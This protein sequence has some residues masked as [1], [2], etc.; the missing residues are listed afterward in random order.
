MSGDGEPGGWSPP[1]DGVL[2]QV[3]DGT[4]AGVGI[5]DPQ[6]RYVYVNPALARMNGLPAEA[7]LG[8]RITEVLPDL[9]DAGEE[10]LRQVLS[11]G[12]SRE[13]P[14]SG[15]THAESGTGRRYWQGAY[16]RLDA[17][18]GTVLGLV[19]IML[20]VSASRQHQQ[21]LERAR[22]RLAILDRAATFIGTTLEMDETC[23]ELAGFLVPLLADIATVEVFPTE[24]STPYNRGLLRLRRAAMAALP[25]LR[26]QVKIFGE[27][28]EYVEYPSGTTIP[29]CL[30][31]GSPVVQ[32]L[33]EDDALGHGGSARE[34]MAAFRSV[35]I[36][37]ALVVPLAAR[38][39]PIGTVTLVRC[40]E[41]PGF[42]ERDT[43]TVQDIV[44]RAAIYLDNAR[45]Y[46]HEHG[47][48]LELQRA[49]MSEPGSPHPSVEAAFRYQPAGS[50]AL[51]GGDWYDAVRLSYGR[52]LLAMG[53]VMGHGVEASVDMSQYRSML[54]FVA[55]ADLP[56][57]RI[58]RRLDTL[59][60]ETE[61]GR[62]A[63]CLLALVDP[64]RNTCTFSSAGHLPPAVIRPDGTV[65]IV[66]VPVGPPL[67][68]GHGGY[69]PVAASCRAGDVLLLYT[70]G[71]V[72]RRGED[73]DASL[74]RLAGL[75]L[76]SDGDLGGLV[77][78]VL[79]LLV[80]EPADDDIAVLAARIMR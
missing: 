76:H 6:L 28:G 20:E 3:L 24:R 42:T 21:E 77:D 12:K 13:V 47:I 1:D 55:A 79:S 23:A 50:T 56:P 35:G 74:D 60:S 34:R 46:T 5:Y 27:P 7:H 2:R 52:T 26:E 45:R 36:H 63:S 58:L 80:V 65:D 59:I 14:S 71:L 40:G 75:R 11:D 48:A 25:N 37:S 78:R 32:S 44:R 62:P 18:D 8:R 41:S 51:V 9:D 39:E 4:P 57:H 30:Q 19:G 43:E 16:H 67:G 72:E 73:I 17:A 61:S 33:F 66:D 49:L 31:S 22:E 29:R 70:D 54:R 10:A 64:V 69:E 68:T 38:G 15:R 53:D